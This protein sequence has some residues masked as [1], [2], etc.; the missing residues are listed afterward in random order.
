LVLKLMRLNVRERELL[1]QIASHE[2]D[3]LIGEPQIKSGRPC[4]TYS[5][6][7]WNFYVH[8]CLNSDRHVLVG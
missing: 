3:I 1:P 6:D 8:Q 2:N 7:N 4:G 5:C